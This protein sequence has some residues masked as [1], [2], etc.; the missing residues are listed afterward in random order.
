MTPTEPLGPVTV[1]IVAE[2][3]LFGRAERWAA[4]FA[5]GMAG[6]WAIGWGIGLAATRLLS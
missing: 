1:R 4:A 6:G 3:G 2:A 5:V